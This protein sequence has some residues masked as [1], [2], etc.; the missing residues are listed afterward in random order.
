MLTKKPL[1]PELCPRSKF[2]SQTPC[3]D[4][5]DGHVR[6][7]K[8]RKHNTGVSLRGILD[9]DKRRGKDPWQ[10]TWRSLFI[11]IY[12]L[13]LLKIRPGIVAS[14]REILKSSIIKHF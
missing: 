2:P 4:A 9:G 12:I 1:F 8:T 13:S 14:R 11:R 7:R 3:N 5:Y 6:Q 10:H